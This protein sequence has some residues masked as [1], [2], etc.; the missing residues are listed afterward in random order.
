MQKNG[1]KFVL[2]AIAV[3][4]LA[5]T[6]WYILGRGAEDQVRTRPI[7]TTIKVVD[8]KTIVASTQQYSIGSFGVLDFGKTRIAVRGYSSPGQSGSS[9]LNIKSDSVGWSV[10]SSMG[11]L[12]TSFTGVKGGTRCRFGTVNFDVL[13]GWLIVGE[14]RFDV[15]NKSQCLVVDESGSVLSVHDLSN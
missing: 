3:I 8:D 7:T 13:D 9:T 11:R 6:S 4:A 10:Q 15:L 5:L 12:S 14:Q 2:P 1:L